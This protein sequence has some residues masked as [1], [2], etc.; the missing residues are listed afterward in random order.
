MRL[1]QERWVFA[2]ATLDDDG[3]P[4]ATPLFYAAVAGLPGS[5]AP[6]VVFASRADTCHGRAIGDGPTAVAAALYLE[7][8]VLGEVRGLQLRGEV[9]VCSRL[10]ADAAASL[11][12]A[13]LE[14]HPVAAAHLGERDRLYALA[15]TWAK[16][17]DNRIGFGKRLVWTFEPP[18]RRE[19]PAGPGEETALR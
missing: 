17:T 7:T 4:Y 2:L 1:L 18:W 15:I 10:H 9:L 6:L 12:A 5:D 3:L 14:R 13:Y 19:F 8:E 16:L 11:R